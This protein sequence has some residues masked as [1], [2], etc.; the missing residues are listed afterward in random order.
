MRRRIDDAFQPRKAPAAGDLGEEAYSAAIHDEAEEIQRGDTGG[1]GGTGDARGTTV[2]PPWK[3]P[4]TRNRHKEH[5]R[6]G[7]TITM[8]ADPHKS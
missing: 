7:P 8:G 2:K 1:P 6:D 5:K 3:S 4:R